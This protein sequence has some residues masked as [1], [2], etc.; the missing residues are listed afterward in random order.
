MSSASTVL[1]IEPNETS[2]TSYADALRHSGFTVVVVPESTT[3]LD[4]LAEVNPHIVIA[5]FDRHTHDGCVALC[6]RLKA[7]SRTQ[8]IPILFTSAGISASKYVMFFPVQIARE[9]APTGRVQL[10]VDPGSALVYVDG[11][12]VGV[13]TEFSGYKHLELVTGPHFVTI[14]APHYEPLTVPVLVS[15][16]HTVT[17]RGTLTRAY[18]RWPISATDKPKGTKAEGHGPLHG[19]PPLQPCARRHPRSRER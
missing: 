7:D 9:G 2:R 10:D 19:G 6:E 18:G 13:V 4:S 12:H 1:L 3:A 15:R 11:K 8:A 14:I 5:R 16:G 17:Y